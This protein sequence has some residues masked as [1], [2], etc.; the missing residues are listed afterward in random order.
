[1]RRARLL[2]LIAVLPAAAC[3]RAGS[4]SGPGAD[5]GCSDGAHRC[6]GLLYSVCKGGGWVL[7]STCAADQ[8]CSETLGCPGRRRDARP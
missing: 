6:D 8:S 3:N 4:A 1:M 5:A 2:L 7:E